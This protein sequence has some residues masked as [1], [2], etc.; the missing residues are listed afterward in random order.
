MKILFLSRRYYPDRGG[1]EKHIDEISKILIKQGHEILIVTQ[2]KGTSKNRYG[3][4]IVRI[5]QNPKKS[6]EKLH[7][8]KWF[9][10]NRSILQNA[11]IIHAH[12]VY[13]WY[14]PYRFLLLNKKSFVT[15]HGYETYPIKR[16]AIVSRK[17]SEILASG[18]IIV[19]DFM[20]KWYFAKP[21][22][23]IYGGVNIPNKTS[24]PK[25]KY[26]AVFMGRLDEHTG[27]MDY[28]KAVELVREDNPKFKFTIL[29]EGRFANKLKKYSLKKYN[30]DV[31]K[32]FQENNFAFVS[33]YLSIL[34]AFANKRLVIAQYDNPVKKDYLEKTPYKDY[35]D[36]V[37][38]PEAIAGKVNYLL[39]NNKEIEN[40]VNRAF[41]WVQKSSW[42]NVV[43][44]YI[45]LWKD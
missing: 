43:D 37:N 10:K 44:N 35:I 36:I 23:V 4:Q 13:W 6:S 17:I 5:P 22:K 39:K 20:K 21:D 42:E 18:S 29:G 19:G 30:P 41:E 12:D 15:F 45:K 40:K 8:W 2:S 34:E 1:I 16:G 38:T 33:R 14:W 26:S 24:S 9:W 32:F 28:A 11:D 25:N 27:I 3:A 7:V 31:D